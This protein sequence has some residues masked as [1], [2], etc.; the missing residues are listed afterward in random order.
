MSETPEE[1]RLPFPHGEAPAGLFEHTACM[2]AASRGHRSDLTS[3]MTWN[4]I[5]LLGTVNQ[6]H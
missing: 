2:K 4:G 1:T 3:A 5:N 6:N